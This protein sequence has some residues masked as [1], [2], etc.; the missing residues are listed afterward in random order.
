MKDRSSYNTPVLIRN[1]TSILSP[2]K[3]V[4]YDSSKYL[5]TDFGK[6]AVI[7]GGTSSERDVSLDSGKGVLNALLSR[8]VDAHAIDP[9]NGL[10]PLVVGGF[11]SA[12]LILHGKPGEDGG[13][14]GFLDTLGIPYTGSGVMASALAMDKPRSKLIFRE[15]GLP[16]PEFGVALTFLEA[17]TIAQTLTYPLAVKPASEGSSVGVTRVAAPNELLTAFDKAAVYGPVLIEQWLDGKDFF[18]TILGEQALPSVQVN[19]AKGFYDYHAKYLSDETEYHCPALISPE[20]EERIREISY[21][22]FKAVG[23][24]S[25]GRVDLVQDKQGKFWLLEVNT[26]PGMTSHSLV[27]M[28]AKAMGLSYEDTVMIVMGHLKEK[29]L[30][31]AS[32]ATTTTKTNETTKLTRQ[33]GDHA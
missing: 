23:G 27:P 22:A 24:E 14:Q 1:L 30:A 25:W 11:D 9:K 28:A 19:M 7:Y 13:I 6:V 8:G 29:Q 3:E 32:P 16:T 10:M 5:A 18:V 20:C 2:Q 21:R 4:Q 17:Q 26:Q 12:F 15:F 33:I 31:M